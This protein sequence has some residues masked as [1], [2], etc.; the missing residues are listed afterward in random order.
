MLDKL[1]I[2]D[3]IHKG[4]FVYAYTIYDES[5]RS[6]IEKYVRNRVY[7]LIYKYAE[8][9]GL[10]KDIIESIS[11]QKRIIFYE[12]PELDDDQFTR[13]NHF[14]DKDYLEENDKWLSILVP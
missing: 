3:S 9:R 13:P 10:H 11:I 2:A 14:D 12:I 6:I 5:N 4:V 8:S 1:N 7:Q